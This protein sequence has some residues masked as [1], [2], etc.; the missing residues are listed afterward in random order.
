[1]RRGEVAE[2]VVGESGNVRAAVAERRDG[3]REDVQPV[4]QVGA[5]PAGLHVGREVAV[6]GRDDSHVDRDRVAADPLD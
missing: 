4:E 1:M 2:E 5:E 6:R 3:D